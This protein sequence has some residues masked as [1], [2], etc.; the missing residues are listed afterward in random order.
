MYI[1]FI[2]Q[3]FDD[4]YQNKTIIIMN[5]FKE[6]IKNNCDINNIYK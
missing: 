2:D 4:D 5:L 1:I 6:A 3:K